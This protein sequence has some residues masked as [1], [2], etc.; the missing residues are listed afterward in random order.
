MP[1]IEDNSEEFID[2]NYHGIDEV[3]ASHEVRKH[4]EP[5]FT[6]ITND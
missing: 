5:A 2:P 1:Y 3:Y 4:N 6:P